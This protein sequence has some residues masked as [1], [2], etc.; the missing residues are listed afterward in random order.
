MGYCHLDR[1]GLMVSAV[2]FC[3]KHR[4]GTT[5]PRGSRAADPAGAQF[6]SGSLTDDVLSRVHRPAPLA[7]M[8]DLRLAQL[9]SAWTSQ[10]PNVQLPSEAMQQIDDVRGPSHG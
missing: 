3:G 4:T 7:A 1:S 9:A 10:N 2:A 5:A 8:V 6:I